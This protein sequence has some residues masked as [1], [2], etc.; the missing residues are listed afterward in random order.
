MEKAVDIKISVVIP[1]KNGEAWLDDC[2]RAITRQTLFYQ[3]EIIV[4]DSGSTDKTLEIL[5]NYPV[6]VY[7]IP[8]SS[9]NHGAT[10]NYGAGLCKGEYIV[11]TVQ[12]AE[13]TDERWLEKLLEGFTGEEVGGVCGQQVV[14]HDA[15]KNPVEWFR[16]QTKPT[17]SQYYFAT[18]EEFDKLTA[19][20][21]KKICSW[22]NVTA[23][24][25]A[26]V[27]KTI[28]FRPVSFA[29][30]TLWAKDALL[31][32]YAIVYNPAARVYHY[33][34]EH[35]D[36][37]FKRSFTVFYHRYKFFGVV[38]EVQKMSA[39]RKVSILNTLLKEQGLSLK[40]KFTWWKYNIELTRNINSAA[41][42][43]L[44]MLAKG[45][46]YLEEAHERICGKEVPVATSKKSIV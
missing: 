2:I 13:A 4:I 26:V 32:G 38:P 20:D 10:R 11:M 29:E 34:I 21:K 28:P 36:F 30:D 19:S 18:P 23:M 41:A 8:A 25:R 6:A 35:R 5:K 27:L 12:D 3:T 15:D 46:S 17:A 9:Y 24:Y 22:D 42:F 33:H 14:R 43:F 37:T 16:P 44:D 7:S 31:A 40:Q 1:V 39:R 45:T